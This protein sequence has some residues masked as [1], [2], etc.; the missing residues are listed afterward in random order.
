MRAVPLAH[1][2]QRRHTRE[3][4]A[5]DRQLAKGQQV[6][7]L[8]SGVMCSGVAEATIVRRRYA[9][10]VGL[11]AG[12]LH[13]VIGAV[14]RAVRHGRRSMQARARVKKRKLGQ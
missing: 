4:I 10:V 6:G 9:P 3:R 14:R 11:C 2:A 13:V 5:R 12:A 8:A 1:T 7:F